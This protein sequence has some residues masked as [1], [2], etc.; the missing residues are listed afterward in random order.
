M[1]ADMLRAA[2]AVS[3]PGSMKALWTNVFGEISGILPIF[4]GEI[5]AREQAPGQPPYLLS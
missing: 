4:S 2:E 3:G 5:G 1:S